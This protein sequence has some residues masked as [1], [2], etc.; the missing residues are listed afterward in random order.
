MHTN[1]ENEGL[2]YDINFNM[3]NFTGKQAN[4]SN[5]YEQFNSDEPTLD[6][7]QLTQYFNKLTSTRQKEL[8]SVNLLGEVIIGSTIMDQTF[9][10]CLNDEL[11]ST[12]LSIQVSSQELIGDKIKKARTS[13]KTIAALKTIEEGDNSAEINIKK[14]R[15]KIFKSIAPEDIENIHKAVKKKLPENQPTLDSFFKENKSKVNKIDTDIEVVC[16]KPKLIDNNNDK[17]N[18]YDSKINKV[19]NTRRTTSFRKYNSADS[20]IVA[21]RSSTRINKAHNCV[22]LMTTGILLSEKDQKIITNLGGQLV[23]DAKECTHLIANWVIKSWKFLSCLNRG[24]SIVSSNY[25]ETSKRAN[26]FLG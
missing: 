15:G 26:M 18:C 1:N 10:E 3:G 7:E 12:Q 21:T 4:P 23:F 8:S 24:I 25:L 2:F 6:E 13:R 17:E 16:K 20:A 22:K 14:R 11:N 5:E 19:K 9:E